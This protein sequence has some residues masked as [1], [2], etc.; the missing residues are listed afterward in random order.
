M[1]AL[2]EAA[3]FL[4]PESYGTSPFAAP[5][6]AVA[7]LA[8]GTGL[9]VVVR[10]RGR[11]VSLSFLAATVA[12]A[13]YQFAFSFMLRAEDAETAFWWARVAY[14]GIPFIVPAVYHFS[15]HLLGLERER[16]AVV[17]IAWLLGIV[18]AELCI[19]TDLI[20]TGVFHTQWGYFARV[21]LWNTPFLV[22]SVGLLT[23]L[24][25]DFIVS[26]REAAPLQRARIRWFAIPLTVACL[27]FMDYAPS[28]GLPIWPLGFVFF[29]VFLLSAA[30][31]VTQFHLP[32]L[33]PAYVA[34][35]VVVAMRDPLLVCDP[36]GRIAL[37]N[38]AAE[39]MLGYAPQELS[40]RSISDVLDPPQREW[41]ID[42]A[43]RRGPGG[44]AREMELV[45]R[46][47]SRIEV[48]VSTADLPE[49]RGT[50]VGFV[51]VARDIRE[52]KR[53]AESLERR[54]QHFRALIENALD[55]ITVLDPNGRITYQS[56]S[57]QKVLGYDPAEEIG[58]NVF[59]RVHEDDLPSIMMA[60]HSL[61][62]E[63]GSVADVEGRI[64]T[65]DG[66]YRIFE[67]RGANLLGHPAVDGIVINGRDVT[68]ERVLEAQLQQAQKM[69][70]I[71]RLA[72][73]IAH[74]F[75]NILTA[76][77]GHTILI[78]EEVPADSDLGRELEEVRRG[79]DRA[80][81]LTDQ[82]LAFSRR[83]VVR[84][85]RLDLNEVVDSMQSMLQRLIGEEMELV[86]DSASEPVEVLA[87]RG[88]IEQ[89]LMNLVVNARDAMPGGGQIRVTTTPVELEEADVAELDFHVAPGHYALLAVRD[90]GSGMDDET[91]SRAFEPFFTT[92]APGQG[93]GLGLA[94][95]YGSVRQAGGYVDIQTA[96][97]AGTVFRIYLPLP[98]AD[99]EAPPLAPLTAGTEGQPRVLA[100]APVDEEEP[101]ARPPQP[102]RLDSRE[103]QP[104]SRSAPEAEGR[105]ILV[106]EDEAPV[107]S[108]IRKVLRRRGY[109][110]LVAGDG[111]EALQRLDEHDGRVDLLIADLVMPG[112]SGREV[113]EQCRLQ[114]TDIAVIFISGYTADEVMRRGIVAGEHIF[115][116]KPFTP[117]QLTGL[118]AEVL[119]ERAMAQ[120]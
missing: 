18:Y 14:M 20:L 19:G 96:P 8:I 116:P 57:V 105:T 70:A 50:P 23:L 17:R 71:G 65:V 15:V 55:T 46:D 114:R 9:Y 111:Q 102:E 49:R 41:L 47:L 7:V 1:L 60:F 94:T 48:A 101:S 119:E 106:V 64:A 6:A 12:L 39:Q 3:Q 89:A 44:D 5:V 53:A 112:M 21:T 25:R 95:V 45:A 58:R 104:A 86:M 84:P 28:M 59:E 103:E 67:L 79:A 36:S 99:A 108:L 120:G 91:R 118:V 85:E 110:V 26:Y 33:T 81:R 77:Q 117:G 10:E 68:E 22:W 66:S 43:V 115:L 100:V 80:A 109:D 27:G 34:D 2:H 107:R 13:V 62:E 32:S 69:E 78:Q 30:W 98:P 56:P 35:Q 97:G 72:G 113:A 29:P 83:Q 40:G 61:M 31:A 75:N 63:P 54:E 88:R 52:Q 93:T 73:G 87:D 11:Q 92:K 74:D 90:E 37:A 16:G 76:I 24:I 51:V 38:P 4:N 42:P 82:L